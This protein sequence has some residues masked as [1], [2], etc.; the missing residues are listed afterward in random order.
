MISYNV[1]AILSIFKENIT[2][3]FCYRGKLKQN[4]IPSC[5]LSLIMIFFRNFI[6]K[7]IGLQTT[8]SV[9]CFYP[10]G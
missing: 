5:R 1:L 7:E 4:S 2:V 6:A 10:Q 3:F 8:R 9:L